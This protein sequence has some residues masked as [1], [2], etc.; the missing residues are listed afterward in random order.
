MTSPTPSPNDR[1]P[2]FTDADQKE[3]TSSQPAE[4]DLDLDRALDEVEQS[5]SD[6]KQRYI[7]VTQNQELQSQLRAREAELKKE[8]RRTPSYER[9]RRQPLRDELR[10]IQS[11]L[12]TIEITLESQLFNFSS[13]KEPFWQAIRFGG[14]GIIVGWILKSCAS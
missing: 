5:L 4:S 11:Q 1:T 10:H 14:L 12:D 2:N 8:L 6:L 7:E 9:S 3:A 13:L